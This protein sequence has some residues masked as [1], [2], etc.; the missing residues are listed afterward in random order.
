M[1]FAMIWRS[2]PLTLRCSEAAA[3]FS[4]LNKSLLSLKVTTF[5]LT[6][7][8]MSQT[9]YNPVIPSKR[10]KIEKYYGIC[11]SLIPK[12]FFRHENDQNRRSIH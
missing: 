2:W 5:S 1:A 9:K 12:G 6:G 4:D 7:L 10:K 3:V 11:K 8:G